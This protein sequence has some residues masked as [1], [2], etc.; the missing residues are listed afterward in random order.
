[1]HTC[2]K[3]NDA[4]GLEDCNR[5][6]HELLRKAA[7]SR[8]LENLLSQL[9]EIDRSA[10]RKSTHRS[11]EEREQVTEEHEEVAE[12]ILAH[13]GALADMLMNHHIREGYE[14]LKSGK[15]D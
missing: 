1:M 3:E 12:A 11:S 2:T 7:G 15:K 6:F 9:S 14:R 10:R 4:E 8:Y 5:R 13:D